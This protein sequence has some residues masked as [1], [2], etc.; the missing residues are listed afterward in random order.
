MKD[1]YTLIA[2]K[3]NSD[4]YCS[5]CLMDS[6]SSDFVE[7]TGIRQYII[8]ALSRVLVENASLKI[9]EIGYNHIYLYK[10]GIALI[11]PDL[12]DEEWS[13]ELLKEYE[14]EY[15][16]IFEEAKKLAEVVLNKNKKEEEDRIR[17]ENEKQEK[18]KKEQE[19]QQY[20]ALQQKFG[21]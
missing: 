12:D 7:A 5:G 19:Y 13:E 9:N 3:P 1:R 18:Y 20:L 15:N 11:C 14:N 17:I 16:F 6:Y 4:D 21:K 10:N 8:N 2:Y